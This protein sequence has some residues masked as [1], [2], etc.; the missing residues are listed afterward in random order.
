MP[1]VF[2]LTHIVYISKSYENHRFLDE[3]GGF[4]GASRDNGFAQITII[5]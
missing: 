3:N 2:V 5:A 4:Y 1:C